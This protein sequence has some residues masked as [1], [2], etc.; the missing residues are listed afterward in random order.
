MS[1]EQPV[2]LV[3]VDRVLFDELQDAKVIF[4]AASS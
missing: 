4:R 1:T 2:Q 3:W